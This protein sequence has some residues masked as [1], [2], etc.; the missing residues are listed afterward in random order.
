MTVETKLNDVFALNYLPDHDYSAKVT[1][2]Y[3][4]HCRRPIYGYYGN[5]LDEYYQLCGNCKDDLAGAFKGFL[6]MFDRY[7]LHYLDSLAEGTTL[8]DLAGRQESD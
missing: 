6:Q 8:M 7:E 3:C 2:K 5:D 1:G 4:A